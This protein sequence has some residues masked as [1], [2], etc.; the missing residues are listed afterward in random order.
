MIIFC[1]Q[2]QFSEDGNAE[3]ENMPLP[4]PV[5]SQFGLHIFKI[6]TPLC[7]ALSDTGNLKTPFKLSKMYK[8]CHI[9]LIWPHE[10]RSTPV[11]T[12]AHSTSKL[13][14]ASAAAQFTNRSPQLYISQFA[15]SCCNSLSAWFHL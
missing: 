7:L 2:K 5:S 13:L 10:S 11:R 3:H 4:F 6:S 15:E 8:L 14:T 12:L 1:I 9:Q